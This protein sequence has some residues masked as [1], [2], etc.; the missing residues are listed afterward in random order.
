MPYF[1]EAFKR[2]RKKNSNINIFNILFKR[3]II[4]THIYTFKYLKNKQ[5]VD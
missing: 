2:I 1:Y 5:I 4:K 3:N